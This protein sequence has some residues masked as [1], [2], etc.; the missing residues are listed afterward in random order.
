MILKQAHEILEFFQK[1]VEY[2]ILGENGKI[3]RVTEENFWPDF[4]KYFILK[5]PEQLLKSKIGVCFD[6]VELSRILFDK[7]NISTKS[8]FICYFGNLYSHSILI[9]ESDRK[10]YW[11]ETSHR[12]FI[13]I[14]EYDSNEQLLKDFRHKFVHNEFSKVPE[15][16]DE[17]KLKIF[18]YRRPKYGIN[19]EQ[20]FEYMKNSKEIQI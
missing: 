11:L 9:F 4:G 7:K 17:L 13:G 1:N 16:Y 18:E 19:C 3:H 15:N 6:Q 2:G 20:Y 10:F 14:H 12:A 5:S 8:Y